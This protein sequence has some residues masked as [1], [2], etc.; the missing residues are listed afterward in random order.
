VDLRDPENQ[1]AAIHRR[2]DQRVFSGAERDW[3]TRHLRLGSGAAHRARWRLWAAKESAFKVARKIDRAVCFHPRAFD[4][5]LA[6]GPRAVVRHAIGPFDVWISGGDDWVHAVA[7]PMEPDPDRPQSKL[8]LLRR[9]DSGHGGV[10]GS[11]LDLASSSSARAR[12][13]A[14]SAVAAALSMETE[15]VEIVSSGRIP[16]AIGISRRI[17]LP[18]DLSLS[19]HGRF[20]ACAWRLIGQTPRR[21][22]PHSLPHP[23]LGL[24]GHL[25]VC[26]G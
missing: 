24:R 14:G 19:H 16:I 5:S 10:E 23:L 1:P 18:V 20:V 8:R 25:R 26:R 4:V 9:G 7:A 12:G 17:R 3:V 22:D 13:V 15:D 11:A 21:S 2:F 6:G